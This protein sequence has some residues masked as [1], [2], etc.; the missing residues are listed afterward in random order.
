M[1]LVI[2][3]LNVL[4]VK[5]FKLRSPYKSRVPKDWSYVNEDGELDFKMVDFLTKSDDG[6]DEIGFIS[7]KEKS[8]EN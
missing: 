1:N 5:K 3:L 2:I 6:D 7:I 8:S 4:K